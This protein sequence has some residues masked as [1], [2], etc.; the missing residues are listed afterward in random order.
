M[1]S[2]NLINHSLYGTTKE[3][4]KVVTFQEYHQK[5]KH[6]V[7]PAD[8]LIGHEQRER[9]YGTCQDPSRNFS[10]DRGPPGVGL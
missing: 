8:L 3:Y 2:Q 10:G 4:Q 5:R 1:P 9:I 7:L 6:N